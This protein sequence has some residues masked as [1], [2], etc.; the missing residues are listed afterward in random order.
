MA[1]LPGVVALGVL[2]A[3][4]VFW[5]LACLGGMFAT[6]WRHRRHRHYL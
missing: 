2:G 5:L 6:R 4:L 1:P 3:F